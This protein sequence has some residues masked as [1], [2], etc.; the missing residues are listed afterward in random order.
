MSA[1]AKADPHGYFARK[2]QREA[3]IR[4]AAPYRIDDQHEM[5][6]DYDTLAA[7]LAAVGLTVDLD[8]VRPGVFRILDEASAHPC[9]YVRTAY[10]DGKAAYEADLARHPWHHDD[11][12]R[13]AWDDLPEYARWSWNRNPTQR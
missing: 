8:P 11:A 4:A 5:I 6:A 7:R 9:G 10:I 12:P 13:P 1:P 2:A 3:A